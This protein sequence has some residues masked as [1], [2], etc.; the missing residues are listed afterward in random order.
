MRCDLVRSHRSAHSSTVICE[1]RGSVQSPRM[2][3]AWT[4]AMN[5]S[6]STLR[7]K[8][9]DRSRPSRVAVADPPRFAAIGPFLDVG[10]A[11]DPS[12]GYWPGEAASEDVMAPC[13]PNAISLPLTLCRLV[14]ALRPV[15]V[16]SPMQRL[17]IRA[18]RVLDTLLTGSRS[19][20]AAMEPVTDLERVR[21]AA[22]TSG[23]MP[24]I[25]SPGRLLR[26]R[27]GLPELAP[28]TLIQAKEAA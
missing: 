28:P 14:R 10:H 1:R 26:W 24:V 18:D 9:L 17:T 15:P 23:C 3:S 2:R 7:A 4:V 13:H 19:L 11:L 20:L 21:T 16:R 8:L 22:Q 27:A 5:R 12:S 25:G 6:A